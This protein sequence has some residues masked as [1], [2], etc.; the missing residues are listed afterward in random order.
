MLSIYIPYIGYKVPLSFNLRIL[1]GYLKG[2]DFKHWKDR[3]KIERKISGGRT[4]AFCLVLVAIR[5]IK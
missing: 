1:R 2:L 5:N 4:Y 3:V